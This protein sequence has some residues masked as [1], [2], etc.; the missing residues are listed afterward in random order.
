MTED[1]RVTGSELPN[2]CILQLVHYLGSTHLLQERMQFHSKPA[3]P[4]LHCER[5]HGELNH[6]NPW[7]I[8]FLVCQMEMMSLFCETVESYIVSY[9]CYNTL[10]QIQWLKTT[11]THHLQ[12][13]WSEVLNGLSGLNSFQVSGGIIHFLAFSSLQ[14]LLT[15]LSSWPHYSNFCFCG[16]IF[17]SD[18]D[19]L[20]LFI[21]WSWWLHWLNPG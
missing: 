7:N 15:F 20:S 9:G 10:P 17:F 18:S 2:A 19:S 6:L 3:T 1:K 5:K 12:F 13:W 16:H 4:P 14:R 11:R 21:K 8:S